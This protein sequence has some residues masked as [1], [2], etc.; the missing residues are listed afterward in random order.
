MCVTPQRPKEH[1]Y[2]EGAGLKLNIWT[3]GLLRLHR[4]WEASFVV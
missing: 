2:K 4:P 1:P 3:K